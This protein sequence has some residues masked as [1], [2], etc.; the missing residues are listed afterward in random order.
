MEEELA[1]MV[2]IVAIVGG[3]CIGAYSM[4]LKARS[5]EMAHRERL[6]MIEKGLV[7]APEQD[8]ER[9]DRL[10]GGKRDWHEHG[11]ARARQSGIML[12]GVGVGLAILIGLTSGVLAVGLGVGGFVFMVGLARF[13]SSAWDT[14][15]I[16][17]PLT[18]GRPS[19]RTT[20]LSASRK[21]FPPI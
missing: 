17:T 15:R 11:A 9:F 13:V 7:P 16:D 19:S 8:P 1:L 14:R 18:P 6:A 4:Y 5:R 10:T 20:R 2:P 12:M 3:L 21:S